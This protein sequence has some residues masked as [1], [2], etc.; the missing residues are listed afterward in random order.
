[1]P[2]VDFMALCDYVRGDAGLLHA[3]GLGIDRVRAQSIPTI[4]NVGIAARLTLTRNECDRDHDVQLI[5]QDQD[6]G[7]RLELRASQFQVAY[8]PNVPAGWPAYASL[9]F[10]LGLPL[11]RYGVHSFELLING[12]SKKSI[13]IMVERPPEAPNDAT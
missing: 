2:E 1:M 3:M 12:H 11:Q 7:G 8:P 6:G 9:S 4:V 5:F 10:R 13:S